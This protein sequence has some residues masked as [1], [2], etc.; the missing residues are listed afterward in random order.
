MCSPT[1]FSEN[2]A[3]FANFGPL[4]LVDMSHDSSTGRHKGFCFL[5]Y[6]DVRGADAALRAMNGFEL[7]GRAIKVM[8]VFSCCTGQRRARRLPD[9][10]NMIF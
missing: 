2:R 6:V 5:E 8:F 3:I 1:H 4:K 10:I 7:A 9:C